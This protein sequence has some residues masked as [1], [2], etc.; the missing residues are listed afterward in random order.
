VTDNFAIPAGVKLKIKP[1]TIIKIKYGKLISSAGMI[2]AIGKPDSMIIFTKPDLDGF[3]GGIQ[4]SKFDQF[5]YNIIEFNG[6]SVAQSW[7]PTDGTY[8]SN[9]IIRNFNSGI[10]FDHIVF[11]KSNFISNVIPVNMR[12]YQATAYNR[13]I[14]N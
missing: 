7:A 5:E 11:K 8:L 12:F 10:N 2:I 3:G 4:C 1:G 6:I 9:C 14:T 13:K